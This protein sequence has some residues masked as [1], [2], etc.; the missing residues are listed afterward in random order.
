MCNHGCGDLK[1]MS[2]GVVKM[3]RGYI[4]EREEQEIRSH[5]RKLNKGIYNSHTY[6]VFTK[7]TNTWTL[8]KDIIIF[9]FKWKK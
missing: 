7:K 1:K 4:M 6:T 2:T 9:I 8:L 5:G 3:K